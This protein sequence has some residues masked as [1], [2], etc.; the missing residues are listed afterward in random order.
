MTYNLSDMSVL[1]E[2]FKHH[3]VDCRD[4]IELITS[5]FIEVVDEERNTS[6]IP[7]DAIAKIKK[8]DRKSNMPYYSVATNTGKVYYVGSDIYSMLEA[9]TLQSWY[10]VYV[11]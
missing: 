3:T 11:P 6:F 10:E 9:I 1:H 5:R 7:I 4:M 2:K 8:N